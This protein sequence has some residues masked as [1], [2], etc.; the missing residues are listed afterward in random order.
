VRVILLS[1][2]LDVD[3]IPQARRHAFEVRV[4]VGF[5]R[6]PLLLLR[7]KEL[8]QLIQQLLLLLLLLIGAWQAK[9]GMVAG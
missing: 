3:I 5:Q 9:G 7:L 1:S 2:H 4:G 6:H 8:I